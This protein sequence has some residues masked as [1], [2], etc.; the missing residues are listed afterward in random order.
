MGGQGYTR[1][2]T[3]LVHRSVFCS[4]DLKPFINLTCVILVNTAFVM[5]REANKYVFHIKYI[6]V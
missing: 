1:D 3:V 5:P 6:N 2:H 4:H